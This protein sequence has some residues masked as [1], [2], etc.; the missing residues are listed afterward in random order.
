MTKMSV[1]PEAGLLGYASRSMA[2]LYSQ[3]SSS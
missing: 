2:P 1:A 3:V